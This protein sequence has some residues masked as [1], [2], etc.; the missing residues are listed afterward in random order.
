MNCKPSLR[1]RTSNGFQ[2]EDFTKFVVETNL[3]STQITLEA[4][5]ALNKLQ[6]LTNDILN[7][8]ADPDFHPGALDH[9]ASVQVHCADLVF[10]KVNELNLETRETFAEFVEKARP[11][12]SEEQIATLLADVESRG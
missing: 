1:K 6:D 4:M 9:L 8:S 2:L 5:Q 3:L 7:A 11:M 10:A 12:Y